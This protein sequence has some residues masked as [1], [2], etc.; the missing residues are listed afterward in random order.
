MHSL[1]HL[2]ERQEGTGVDAIASVQDS[3]SVD[4]GHPQ[5]VT[6]ATEWTSQGD[7]WWWSDDPLG[8]QTKKL[9]DQNN[10]FVWLTCVC[11][12]V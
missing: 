10:R 6:Q 9:V 11:C 8:E 5:F 2:G 12:V 3:P 1:Q 4:F 7:W